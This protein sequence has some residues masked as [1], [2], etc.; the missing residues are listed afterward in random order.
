M[1]TTRRGRSFLYATH[2]THNVNAHSIVVFADT[3]TAATS[4]VIAC[5]M[6]AIIMYVSCYWLFCKSAS[7]DVI[8]RDR[9]K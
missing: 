2:P 4:C 6:A 7:F 9:D 8:E 5:L 1:R 3:A